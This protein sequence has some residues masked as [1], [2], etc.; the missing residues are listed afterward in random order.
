MFFN[1]WQSPEI[2]RRHLPHWHQDGV[3]YFVTFRLADSIP[4]HQLRA[5]RERRLL[6]D[7]AHTDTLTEDQ[8]KER[9]ELFNQQIDRW[10]DQGAGQCH[11]SGARHSIIVSNALRYF[12]GERYTLNAHV[13]MPNH[14][15]VLIQPAEG[16]EL[17]KI[18]HSIKSFS[19]HEINKELNKKGEFWQDESYD[20]IVRSPAELSHFREYIRRNPAVAKVTLPEGALY[21]R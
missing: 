4:K 9:D 6:W 19:A 17:S 20:R 3:I 1:P 2:S 10:L 18:L 13:V 15:H 21:L 5:W 7:D 12:D 11:L 16:H 8:I 14:V